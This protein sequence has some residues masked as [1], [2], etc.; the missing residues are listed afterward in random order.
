MITDEKVEKALNYMAE[1]DKEFANAHGLLEGLKRQTKTIEGAIFLTTK[2][3]IPERMAQVHTD[4]A[5]IDHTHKISEAN[6]DYELL[7]TRRNTA[8][9]IIEVW[10]T[11]SANQRRGNV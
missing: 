4:Q 2:G 10:R 3:T 11:E 7:K 5:Y 6:Y 9:L 8:E 1:T